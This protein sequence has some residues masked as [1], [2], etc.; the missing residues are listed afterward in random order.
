MPVSYARVHA[1][2]GKTFLSLYISF[3]KKGDIRIRYV[4]T[5]YD[6]LVNDVDKKES[7]NSY[8]TT[9]YESMK[10]YARISISRRSIVS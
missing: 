7:N 4:M 10:Y 6:V 2:R 1:L 3:F 5:Y 9:L 8:V